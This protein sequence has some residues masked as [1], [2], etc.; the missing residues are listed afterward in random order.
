MADQLKRF[1]EA[2]LKIDVSVGAMAAATNSKTYAQI[3]AE[4]KELWIWSAS[5]LDIEP[6]GYWEKLCREF[7]DKKGRLL[8]Y[9][10]PTLEIAD[11]LA[12]R[13]E[14]ELS[15]RQY[16]DEG[17]SIQNAEGFG[18]T[19]FIVVTNFSASMPYVVLTNPG[20]A[21]FSK[22][23]VSQSVWAIG[24]QAQDFFE[25]PSKFGEMLI[26]KARAAGLGVARSPDNFFPMGQ[27]LRNESGIPFRNYPSV[28]H[29]IGIRLEHPVGLFD[30]EPSTQYRPIAK[31]NSENEADTAE[32][33]D[34]QTDHAQNHPLKFFP[35]F[36]RAYRRKAGEL[37]K[38]V[39]SSTEKKEFFKF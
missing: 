12:F 29:L 28:D 8:T 26:Q 22:D 23:G 9:F 24:N 7:L 35:V 33:D 30:A 15:I 2:H 5:P 32:H 17:N 3:F 16:D 25:L 37:S 4:N 39:A 11:R 34:G 36:I 21:D 10:V 1:S 13:F 27:G 14:T 38:K 18:A 31:S 20:S 19:V 6:L